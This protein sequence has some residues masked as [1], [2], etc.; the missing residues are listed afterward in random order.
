MNRRK[1]HVKMEAETGHKPRIPGAPE[2]GIGR[3]ERPWAAAGSPALR[4]PG[5]TQFVVF[6]YSG[7]RNLI[8]SAFKQ[9]KAENLG[10]NETFITVFLNMFNQIKQN[11]HIK[12]IL[13]AQSG[14]ITPYKLGTHERMFEP[15][16]HSQIEATVICF[17]DTVTGADLAR[18]TPVLRPP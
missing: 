8:H 1:G 4:H 6:C 7:H 11:Q 12:K 15:P 2:A 3:R 17:S 13:E 10:P 18:S 9:L 14:H 16:A 5:W